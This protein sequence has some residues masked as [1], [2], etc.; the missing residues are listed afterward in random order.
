[1][2]ASR[3]TSLVNIVYFFMCYK[4]CVRVK[5]SLFRVKHL[6]DNKINFE[7]DRKITEQAEDEAKRHLQLAESYLELLKR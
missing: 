3:D 4:A 5:V 7:R 1:M 6:E 2:L